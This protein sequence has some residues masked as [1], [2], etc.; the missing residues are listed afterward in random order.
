MGSRRKSGMSRRLFLKATAA[1][2]LTLSSIPTIIVP[3]RVEAYQPGA[4]LHPNINSLR[5]AGLRDAAMTTAV[6]ERASWNAQEK[7]VAWDVVQENIDKLAVALAEES[8]SADAWKKI[9]VKPP[10]K[11]WADTVVAIKTNNI[12]QQHTR[13]A[14][15]SKVCHVLTDV[16]GVTGSNVHIYDGQ[17]GGGLSRS[18]PFS[19][20]PEGVHV[21]DQWGGINVRTDVPAPY[22]Q[23]QRQSR[24]LGH[25]VRDEVDILINIALCKGH[26]RE[27]GQFTMCLKNHFGTFDPGPAHG[28]GGGADYLIAIN[29]TP[30]I[31]GRMD[32]ATGNALFPRQQ[33]CIVDALWASQPG[34]G[35]MPTAQLNAM[36]MGTFGPAVDYVT[37]MR[38]RKD[39]MNWPVN[40]Q[41]ATRM[42][43]EFGYGAG[44]LP[45]GG[46]IIDALG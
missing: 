14:V 27:F 28:E 11:S 17:H 46:Q 24:C 30:A 33:L 35:G 5:V 19:G 26:G 32:P 25:L 43:T 40:E 45:N 8:S 4:K 34:P 36:T 12:A 22:Q 42:L 23:G 2:A 16:L 21:G 3:R 44:D 41:V 7:L 6:N 39:T 9:L 37:A 10:G 1:G 13:S 20:L 31:L 29:K 18:T 38:L 15:M